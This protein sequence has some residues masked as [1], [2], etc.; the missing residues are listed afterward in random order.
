MIR[1][2]RYL[3]EHKTAVVI[4]VIMLAVQAFCDLSLPRYTSKIVDIGIAQ[5]GIENIAPK[6]ISEASY[7]KLSSMLDDKDNAVIEN[8][9]IRSSD[10][11]SI[12]S[13][14]N[15]LSS[16]TIE[17]LDNILR[18]PMAR[19]F[20]ESENSAAE[21]SSAENAELAGDNTVMNQAALQFL[22]KEYK[23]LG[24]D[25][26]SM[27]MSYL[28]KT[29]FIMILLSFLMLSASVVANFFA[30]RTGA[31][32]GRNLRSRIF[33]RV[34]TFSN[35]EI[36]RFSTAS[37][38]TRST[39]DIQQIQMVSIMFLRMVLYAPILGVGGIALVLGTHTGMTWIIVVGV[40]TIVAFILILMKIALPKFRIMQE[41]VDKMNLISREI[42]TGIPVIR[43]FNRQKLEADRFEKANTDLMRTQLFTNRVMTLM[44]P[45]MM[46]V[47]NCISVGIVWQG[48]KAIDAG[49]LQVGE[50]IAFIT[51]AMMIVMSFMMITMM[52]IFLPRA[53]V[54]A[55]RID[56]VI[57]TESSI[58][59]PKLSKDSALSDI[60]GIIRFEDVHFSYPDA[61]KKVL[62]NINFVLEPG[63]TLAVIG[64]TGC[65]K[66]TLLQLILRF[67]DV[68]E[69]RIT[70]D[71]I[72]IREISQHTLHKHIGY[73][74]QQGVLFSGSIESNL[75]FG[76][77]NIS[78]ESMMAAADIAQASDFIEAKS[79]KYQSSIAQDGSNVSGGQRQRL[80]IARA[81]AK[82]PKIYLFDDSFSA[83]DFKTDA[84]LRHALAK[85]ISNAAVMIVAQRVSTIMNCD[86]IVVLEKGKIV[87]M[88]THKELLNDCSEYI[89]IVESQLSEEDLDGG[90][91]NE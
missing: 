86:C 39:N 23:N 40:I 29:G 89:E 75:K 48:S 70:L 78:D 28:K 30:A 37:L 82:D 77:D 81:I 13:L 34:V 83:L 12:L 35:A 3:M 65:G 58:S 59:D 20:Y 74:P 4:I 7:I 25:T 42:L 22:L 19:M 2:G 43:A 69:G 68:T 84:A 54:A 47:M 38:I 63:K 26:S 80:A 27:Q 11:A 44:M 85:K 33:S 91:E 51:Y 6:F 31:A 50:M 45:T 17:N 57:S 8:S 52:A 62:E 90:A 15:G 46:M 71:G 66:S 53:G 67:Y 61:E 1:I 72:D 49:N 36:D 73:I 18:L 60:K 88:G 5:S 76:G 87:G 24:I 56:E 41:L 55:E 21:L 10:S 79:E 9:Y 32:I 16:E 14:K 64:S